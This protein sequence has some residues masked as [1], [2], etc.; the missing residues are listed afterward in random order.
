MRGNWVVTKELVE[1]ALERGLVE[2]EGDKAFRISDKGHRSLPD[3]RRAFETLYPE[4]MARF[5]DR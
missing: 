4:S 5:V 1:F 2:R 3:F